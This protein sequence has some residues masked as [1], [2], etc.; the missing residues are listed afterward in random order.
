MIH[1]LSLKTDLQTYETLNLIFPR[2]TELYC[3]LSLVNLT[4]DKVFLDTLM[5][6][7]R[8][9]FVKDRSDNRQILGIFVTLKAHF[10]NVDRLC[11]PFY[12]QLQAP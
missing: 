2:F 3:R 8:P 4:L 12:A 5:S 7:A 9:T 11:V 6:Y 10:G 1:E